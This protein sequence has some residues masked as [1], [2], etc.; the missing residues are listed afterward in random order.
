MECMVFDLPPDRSHRW[1]ETCCWS[2]GTWCCSGAVRAAAWLLPAPCTDPWTH[3]SRPSWTRNGPSNSRMQSFFERWPMK[4]EDDGDAMTVTLSMQIARRWWWR[5]CARC[6]AMRCGDAMRSDSVRCDA[7]AGATPSSSSSTASLRRP[8]RRRRGRRRASC[9]RGR[10]LNS[11]H[12]I[13]AHCRSMGKQQQQKREEK[14][15]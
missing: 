5:M 4:Y 14:H 9:S 10:V 7:P 8:R 15:N 3:D 2:Y 12:Q 13:V 11:W 6:D 1:A